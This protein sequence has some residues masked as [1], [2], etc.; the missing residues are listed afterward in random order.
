MNENAPL[1][2]RVKKV[3]P[4]LTHHLIFCDVY[5]NNEHRHRSIVCHTILIPSKNDESKLRSMQ[6]VEW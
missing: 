6:C 5:A 3:G 4:V 1:Q 2:I